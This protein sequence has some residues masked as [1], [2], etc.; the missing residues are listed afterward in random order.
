[1]PNEL[2]LEYLSKDPVEIN[3]YK[4]DPMIHDRVSTKYSLEFMRTGE[5]AISNAYSLKTS[6]LLLHGTKDQITSPLASK[7]FADNSNG[8]VTFLPIENGYHELH[9]D[10]EK[11]FVLNQI[12]DWIQK[13]ISKP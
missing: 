4:N 6:M 12:C 5:W 1:M 10:L 9:H 3:A 2:D 13:K 11:T 7:E 8:M